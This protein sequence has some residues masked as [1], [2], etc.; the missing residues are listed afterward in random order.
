MKRVWQQLMQRRREVENHAFFVWMNSESVPL[1][2]RFVSA[3]VLIDFIMGF[4][5]MNKWFLS[6]PEPRDTLESGINEHTRE[7]RTH[8]RLFHDNWYELELGDVPSWPA[9]KVLWW[10]FQAKDSAIVRKFGMEILDMAVNFPDPLVRFS[11]MEAIELCGVVFFAN[12]APIA[13]LLSLKDGSSQLYYGE[14]HQVRETGHLHTD[15]TAFTKAQLNDT[16]LGDATLAVNK[17]FERFLGILDQL[18]SYSQRAV[19]DN[20]GHQRDLQDEYLAALAAPIS[21]VVEEN[22]ER[23]CIT[24]SVSQIP[25]LRHQTQRL[26]RLR[27]HPFLDWLLHDESV[28]SLD[29]LRRF[30]ALWGVDIVGYRDFNAYVLRYDDAKS[31][32]ERHINRWTD[33]LATHGRLYLQ[34]WTAL[35]MDAFLRWDMGETMAFYFLSHQTETHR[36][37]MAKVKKHAFRNK[38]PLLRWWIMTA[39]ET[40]GDPLFKAIAPIARAVEQDRNVVLNYWANR[41]ALAHTR[42]AVPEDDFIFTALEIS[43]RE[44]AIVAQVIE[45]VFDNLEEQLTLSHS[46]AVAGVFLKAP[47]TLPPPRMSDIVLR[48]PD[49]EVELQ[50]RRTRYSVG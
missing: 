3:P 43:P 23:P 50:G 1:E 9:G 30:I 37:N 41:H 49:L 33:N 22:A 6:Y 45:T 27:R 28:G 13:S 18:L 40:A 34:D 10:L 7:D 8:S 11:M 19:S 24:V 21:S 12:T 48:G 29:K 31:A 38:E 42:K 26:E 36:R 46:Q 39:L 14:Y 25:L 32:A 44:A 20:D 35:E 17:V 2:L 5:D 47:S 4:A 16:Q 15:E